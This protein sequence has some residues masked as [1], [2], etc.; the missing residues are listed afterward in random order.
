MENVKSH[1]NAKCY[2][3]ARELPL[4]LT[5][6]FFFTNLMHPWEVTDFCR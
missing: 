3:I 5:S 4:H 6:L 1:A 2:R